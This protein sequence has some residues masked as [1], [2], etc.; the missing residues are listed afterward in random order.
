MEEEDA[1]SGQTGTNKN[2][3]RADHISHMERRSSFIGDREYIKNTEECSFDKWSVKV[4]PVVSGGEL[5]C[6]ILMKL[7]VSHQID[8]IHD[9][10]RNNIAGSSYDPMNICSAWTN[11]QWLYDKEYHPK[12][13][14]ECVKM[15][16]RCGTYI[17]LRNQSK[18]G[19]EKAGNNYG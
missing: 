12:R 16:G 17:E 6:D 14:D 8:G 2:Q 4:S 5:P 15:N 13:H 3:S 9:E 11:E 10:R 7:F 19:L 18:I 1:Y